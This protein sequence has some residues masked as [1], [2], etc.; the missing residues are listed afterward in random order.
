MKKSLIVASLLA[1]VATSAVASEPRDKWF[2][3]LE[4]GNTSI[5]VDMTASATGTSAGTSTSISGGFQAIKIG[6][7]F[8]YGRVYVTYANYNTTGN[9]DMSSFGAGYDYLINNSTNWTPFIGANIGSFSYKESGGIASASSAGF[10]TTK[11][12]IDL[13]G[14]S[15]GANAG[16]L[17]S[18]NSNFDLEAGLRISTTS[19]SDNMTWTKNGIDVNLE[20]KVNTISQI[21]IGA[22][23]N[24]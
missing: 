6:K 1:V 3:G 21:Y 8:E 10:T 11:D 9:T 18:I 4:L 14:A 15:F 5:N 23:Y 19:A 2:G 7:Y 12:T 17:Y 20:S 13:S 16:V 22:N 24:F